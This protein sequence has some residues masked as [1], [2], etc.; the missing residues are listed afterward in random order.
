MEH[1]YM[2]KP[3]PTNVTGVP[4]TLSV[5][6]ANGNYR[7][8]GQVTTDLDGFFSFNWKPDIEGKYTVYASFVGSES[9]W[10]S[11]AVTAF[12]VDPAAATPAPTQA[13]TQGVAD[14]YFVPAIAALFVF[15]AVVAVVLILIQR[16]RP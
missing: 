15:I 4:V 6:D 5:V 13:P 7:Q 11:H 12:A 9:Y 10:P 2:Q 8:I 16:K 3:R 14:L 1:V